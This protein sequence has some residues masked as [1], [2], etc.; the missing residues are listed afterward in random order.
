MSSH[1]IATGD[2][3]WRE[4][5]SRFGG[6]VSHV[7]S[8]PRCRRFRAP[9]IAGVVPY[10]QAPRC[11]VAI[12]DPVAPPELKVGLMRHFA[13]SSI[14]EGHGVVIAAASADLA[15]HA[16]DLGYGA[17]R[18]GEEV[19]VDPR[20]DLTAGSVGRELRKKVN[21][22][23]KQGVEVQELAPDDPPSI[24]AGIRRVAAAWLR[25]RGGL[26][27][28][29]PLERVDLSL[30]RRCFYAVWGGDVVGAV[31]LLRI[32]A[33]NGWAIEHLFHA[34]DAP[35]GTT[36]ALVVRAMKVVGEEG[37][38]YATFGP[39]M[40][41]GL[42]DAH[43]LGGAS[44]WL[45]KHVLRLAERAFRLGSI[46]RYREKFGVTRR[47]P[48]YLLF[49]SSRVGPLEVFGLLHAFMAH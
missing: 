9:E 48:S 20:A 12:G 23:Q 22:A 18:Y 32:D 4:L 5:L 30:G 2:D 10:R 49:P 28:I 43:G 25:S 8:D 26:V 29:S 45:A 31:S 21:R 42:E 40:S 16:V 13:D 14:Q 19:I 27:F 7:L 38:E 39:A 37:A 3:D 24:E 46:L 41:P 17:L 33:R 47:E 15:G 6:S 44:R 11:R 1:F 36:E 34:P 35:Q